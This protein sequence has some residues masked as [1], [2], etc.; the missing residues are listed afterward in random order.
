MRFNDMLLK[1]LEFIRDNY[2][3]LFKT[4]DDKA[5]ISSSIEFLEKDK[6]FLSLIKSNNIEDVKR[7]ETLSKELRKINDDFELYKKI[8]HVNSTN[9]VGLISNIIVRNFDA[10][11]KDK[12]NKI[13]I[14]KKLND[15]F[16]VPE[17]DYVGLFNLLFQKENL[18]DSF[19]LKIFLNISYLLKEVYMENNEINDLKKI[20]DI[21][22]SL[23]DVS[24]NDMFKIRKKSS[25][26]FDLFEPQNQKDDKE[27]INLF[28]MLF[29]Y[30]EYEN[31]KII[32]DVEHAKML[33]EIVSSDGPF[34]GL[35]FD[36][37]A[38]VL[39]SFIVLNNR[40][41]DIMSDK[42]GYAFKDLSPISDIIKRRT[43]DGE[44]ADNVI[45]NLASGK[46]LITF[47]EQTS[48]D[49]ERK[50]M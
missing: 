3:N 7:L 15:I 2:D 17:Y 30:N 50:G 48:N 25:S 43:Y 46:T 34:N 22:N 42:D 45:L 38:K 26:M 9:G 31:K 8:N 33:K 19:K 27:N 10:I 21:N 36:Y 47:N 20:D 5:I 18:S 11:F 12:E 16:F 37:I 1:I 41:F 32:G 13:A 14:N 4:N 40:A 39:Y 23:K 29:D 44:N 24:K 35:S 49:K 6:E 28:S